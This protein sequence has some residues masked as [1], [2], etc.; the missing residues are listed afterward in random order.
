MQRLFSYILVILLLWGGYVWWSG[1][2]QSSPSPVLQ[3]EEPQHAEKKKEEEKPQEN[4]PEPEAIEEEQD[5]ETRRPPPTFG[6][7]KQDTAL[8]AE[9][10]FVA[11][12]RDW[13]QKARA[14]LYYIQ[15]SILIE[16][17][18]PI[19]Q[20]LWEGAEAPDIHKEYTALQEEAELIELPP[21]CEQAQ[22]LINKVLQN[23]QNIVEP[24]SDP[25]TLS[26]LEE[27]TL[28]SKNLLESVNELY[29]VMNNYCQ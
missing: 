16:K 9:K 6:D 14:F 26:E 23:L 21:T 13:T 1:R 24:L 20:A 19:E 5:A 3:K 22:P 4:V 8:P 15:S 2:D 29:V 17:G 7:H 12:A 10:R 18:M 11:D 27:A 25:P 28:Q